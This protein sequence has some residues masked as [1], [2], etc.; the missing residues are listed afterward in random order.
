MTSKRAAHALPWLLVIL[1][2]LASLAIPSSAAYAQAELI[3]IWWRAYALLGLSFLLTILALARL[4]GGH[5]RYRMVLFVLVVQSLSEI[6]LIAFVF[7]AAG[8]LHDG[9]HEQPTTADALYFS[10]VSFTTLGYGDF[11]P[12]PAYRLLAACE[13]LLGYVYLGVFVGLINEVMKPR[14]NE[15]A[16]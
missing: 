13:A 11:Q 5:P 2:M 7:R 4:A 6:A 8:L 9:A 3:R 16:R 15:R 14:I 12:P 1:V 10:I